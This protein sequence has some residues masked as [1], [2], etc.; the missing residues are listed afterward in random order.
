MKGKEVQGKDR[1][2]EFAPVQGRLKFA[3]R[4]V[5]EG[6]AWLNTDRAAVG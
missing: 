6:G 1:W 2:L 5:V 4:G 3:L